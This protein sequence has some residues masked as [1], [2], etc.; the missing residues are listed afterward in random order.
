MD[1]VAARFALRGGVRS[2]VRKHS[3]GRL[4]ARLLGLRAE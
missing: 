4:R 2:H 3:G 1:P